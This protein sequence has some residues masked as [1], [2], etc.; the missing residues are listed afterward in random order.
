MYCGQ[1]GKKV[2][3]NMLFCP[4]CGSPIVIPDQDNVPQV[5]AAVQNDAPPRPQSA[6]EPPEAAPQGSGPASIFDAEAPLP[7]GGED[8]ADAQEE[9]EKFVPLSFSF[10]EREAALADM[11][12][13]KDIAKDM[14]VNGDGQA[15]DRQIVDVPEEVVSPARPAEAECRREDRMRPESV[16]RRSAN[17]YIPVKEVALNDI[18]M[19]GDDD[20]DIDDEP[21]DDYDLDEDFDE[22]FD[23]EDYYYEEREEGG[24]MRRHVRGVVGLVLFLLL[25]AICFFWAGTDRGQLTLA[26]FNLAWR[27]QPYAELGYE[28]YLADSKLMAARYYEKALS[29]DAQNY[30]YA[31][32]AMVSYYEADDVEAAANMLRRCIALQPDNAEPYREMLILYPDRDSRPW[33]IQELIRTGYQRTGDAALKDA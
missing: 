8:R 25:I 30:E 19:D 16:R 18:F 29:R 12:K 20:Y 2:M 27:A 14:D 33:E 28:A 23:D 10:E 21:E 31:H 5:P 22:D 32:S 24:F 4:F 26:K 9:E 6:P 17:T 13:A 15:P 1:C 11:D 7:F 3:E